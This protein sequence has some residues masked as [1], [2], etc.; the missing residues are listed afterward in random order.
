M[1][2]AVIGGGGSLGCFETYSPEL[3]LRATANKYGG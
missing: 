1:R 2:E 3:R